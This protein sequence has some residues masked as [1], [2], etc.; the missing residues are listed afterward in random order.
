MQDS[1]YPDI[2]EI[3]TYACAM[4]ATDLHLCVGMPPLYRMN[5]RLWPIEDIQVVKPHNITKII[6]D[7]LNEEQKAQLMEKRVL[8]LSFS[9]SNLGRFRV[10]I[11]SQRGTFAL[12]IRTLPFEIPKLSSLGLP[13]SVGKFI[14]KSRGLVLATGATGSGKSTTLAAILK[15]IN[16]NYN[17]HIITIEDPIEYLHPHCKSLVTQREIGSDAYS[18][19]DALRSA[20][21]EDPDVIMVGEMRDP[22]TISIALTAAET[23]HLVLSTLH[24]IG[25]TKAIDRIID[26]FPGNQQNQIRNQLATVL[27]GIISQQLIP[28]QRDNKLIA[29]AEV[30]ITNTAIKNMIR[31]GKQYQ[32]NNVLQTGQDQGMNLMDAELARL[33]KEGIITL[34]EAMMRAQD[35]ALLQ[36][37]I[38]RS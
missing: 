20:L 34:D 1:V 23:G 5:S 12:A 28:S 16:D 6:E 31:E 26:S 29:V 38:D 35:P 18:F 15:E 4:G 22:E 9:L 7:M 10:N 21:R 13:E 37:F 27:E 8:D 30:L 3:L 19:A 11:Y 32:I 25:S 33:Q 36:Y 17:Y 14:H 2:R 24:T